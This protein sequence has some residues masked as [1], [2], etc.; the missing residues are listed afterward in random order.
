MI[1]ADHEFP[2]FEPHPLLLTGHL[3]T[4]ATQIERRSLRRTEVGY[5]ERLFRVAPDSQVQTFARLQPDPRRAPLVIVLHGLA[6]DS[7]TSYVLGIAEKA[8][9][10]GFSAVRMNLRNCNDT[11][12]LTPT[13]YH[14]GMTG[15]IAAV[16]S[17][18]AAQDGVP[19]IYLAGGSLGGAMILR[20]L[21]ELGPEAP[22]WLRGAAVISPPLD[23]G[24]TQR[25]VDHEPSARLYRNFF[26]D[27][28]KERMRVKIARY[29]GLCDARGLDRI[30]TIR[31]FDE[32]YTS[33]LG[34]YGDAAR[35]YAETSA[36]PVMSRV[37]RPT[38]VV[39]AQDDP[40]IPIEPF[41]APELARSAALRVMI[42]KH[43]GHCAF[44]ARKPV[45]GP[46]WRDIGRFWAENRVVEFLCR[47]D[48][49]ER[50]T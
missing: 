21:G 16:A 35:Y 23:L 42:T 11:E 32:R 24:A 40:I 13:I 26:L 14:A 10:A 41:R 8:F 36:L 4:L 39:H 46:G 45:Q 48:A 5:R 19:R 1:A 27:R 6:G 15:D 25:W 43:G 12:H 34:G 22:A 30:R 29:P 37:A 18:L 47:I 20:L 31:E 44:L 33:V 49:R 7:G 9:T 38:L 3:Q 28:M 50:A 17:E 2:P